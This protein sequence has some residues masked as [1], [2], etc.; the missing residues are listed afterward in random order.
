MSHLDQDDVRPSP[1][2]REERDQLNRIERDIKDPDIQKKC[3]NDVG[4]NSVMVVDVWNLEPL[5]KWY[6]RLDL[7][8]FVKWTGLK[9]VELLPRFRPQKICN[10]E[11]RGNIINQIDYVESLPTRLAW[12][13]R[14]LV[15]S[16]MP[17]SSNVSIHFYFL[18]KRHRQHWAISE[19]SKPNA[20][21]RTWRNH[22]MTFWNFAWTWSWNQTLRHHSDGDVEQN[23]FCEVQRLVSLEAEFEDLR[24]LQVHLPNDYWNFVFGV[25]IHP[26][27]PFRNE[28]PHGFRGSC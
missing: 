16:N 13:F 6:L 2:G 10:T 25:M 21:C 3:F 18:L 14:P 8:I 5:K 7:C 15:G 24:S 9:Q 17:F 22:R 11:N 23:H 19:S 27:L 20:S 28:T 26:V 1:S 4:V 12:H